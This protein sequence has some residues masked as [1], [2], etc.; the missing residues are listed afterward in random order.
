MRYIIENAQ[1]TILQLLLCVQVDLNYNI[2]FYLLCILQ[3]K[4]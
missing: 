1:Q 2:I 4:R 3:L